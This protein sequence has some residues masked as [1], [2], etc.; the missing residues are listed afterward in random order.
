MNESLE[1]L[2]THRDAIAGLVPFLDSIRSIAEIAWRRAEG[3]AAP[4]RA[5]RRQIDAVLESALA[6]LPPDKRASML[7]WPS[8]RTGPATTAVLFVTSERG[9]CGPFTE[10]LIERG[11]DRVR[12]REAA[13]ERVDLLVLGRQGERR[14]AAGGRTVT[15]AHN[16]PSLSVASYRQVEAIALDLLELA[17]QRGLRQITA[18]WNTPI[19]RFESELAGAVILPPEIPAPKQDSRR[20]LVKPQA[21]VRPLLTQVLTERFLL[22]LYEVVLDSALSEQLARVYAM[23]LAADNAKKLLDQLTNDYNVAARYAVTSSLLE[24][25]TGYE[26]TMAQNNRL[27]KPSLY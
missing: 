10:R 3:R 18:F 4:L 26:T 2:Q 24:T 13:G 21:D 14:L 22:G 27:I 20:S 6:G 9:L 16:L 25:L 1:E 23:R 5:Y 7:G 11:L 15:Y 19:G 8:Q 12:N 17:E